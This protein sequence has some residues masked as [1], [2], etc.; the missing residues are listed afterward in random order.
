VKKHPKHEETLESSAE[1]EGAPLSLWKV[2]VAFGIILVI[3][4]GFF[5]YNQYRTKQEQVS[6]QYNGFDFAQAQGGLWVTRIEIGRQPYDIPFYH[7][8]KE[9]EDVIIDRNA[10]KPIE[11]A[12]RQVFIAIDPDA[13]AE[14]V[15]A[16]VEISRI[17]G[18]KYGIYDIETRGALSR[19][20]DGRTDLPVINCQNSTPD[21]VVIQFV[22]AKQNVITRSD[23]Y[24]SCIIINYKNASE[25]VRVADKYAY[26][27]LKIV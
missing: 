18:N 26:M 21:K 3:L 7:H 12:P 16:G 13:G 4:L 20:V 19:P 14:P 1:D 25:S 6:N 10:I 15:V 24:P 22:E 8:P 5:A 11:A 17:T 2:L 23:R 27:L 9:L